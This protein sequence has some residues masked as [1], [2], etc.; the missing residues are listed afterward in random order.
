MNWVRQTPVTATP[1]TSWRETW[2][3]GDISFDLDVTFQ[4]HDSE[5]KAVS[6]LDFTLAEGETLAVVGESGSGKSQAFLSIM[7]L[8]ARNGRASGRA[9]WRNAGWVHSAFGTGSL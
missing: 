7:G 4:L 3:R 5:V 6:G 2:S 1:A 9:F 8:L